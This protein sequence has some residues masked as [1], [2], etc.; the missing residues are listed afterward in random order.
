MRL[1]LVWLAILLAVGFP[2]QQG[3]A[4]PLRECF[5]SAD[6]DAYVEAAVRT[7]GD[8]EATVSDKDYAVRL[9][10]ALD[11]ASVA[12]GYK[13]SACVTVSAGLAS[14][15]LAGIHHGISLRAG[16]GCAGEVSGQ[17]S[18]AIEESMQVQW[19]GGAPLLCCVC[20]CVRLVAVVLRGGGVFWC[21]QVLLFVLPS[22]CYIGWIC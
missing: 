17:V 10:K 13:S 3:F 6:S 2:V 22:L 8:G 16:V 7:L 4:A 21:R 12:T 19:G 14:G 15:D 20:V 1:V 5:S 9:L 18:E 11:N